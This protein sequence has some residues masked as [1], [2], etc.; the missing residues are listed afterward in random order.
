MRPGLSAKAAFKGKIENSPFGG[1]AN[2]RAV[3]GS[4]LADFGPTLQEIS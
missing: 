3:K 4:A 1:V 2:L